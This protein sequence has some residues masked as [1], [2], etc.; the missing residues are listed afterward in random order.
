[1]K[2]IWFLTARQ[3]RRGGWRSGLALCSALLSVVLLS[4]T[5]LGGQALSRALVKGDGASLLAPL[6][7]AA[8]GVL[9]LFLLLA[10]GILIRSSFSASLAQ[11]VRC[12]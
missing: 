5:L 7:R 4:G 9:I 8:A 11:R 10:T 1:M 2:A 12:V 3:L 6:V